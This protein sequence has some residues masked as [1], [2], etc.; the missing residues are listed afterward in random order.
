MAAIQISDEL[1]QVIEAKVRDGRAE[2]A[3]AYVE[4]AV[5]R[6]LDDEEYD[7]DEIVQVALAGIADIEA[8]RYVTIATKEDEQRLHNSL[9]ARVEEKLKS[10]T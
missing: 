2:S 4:E 8:G 9:M 10:G 3:A 6:L 1:Q 7:D 5:R